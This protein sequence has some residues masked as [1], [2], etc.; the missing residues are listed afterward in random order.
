M[1]KKF[2]F[3]VPWD[4]FPASGSFSADFGMGISIGGLFLKFF[5]YLQGHKDYV[6]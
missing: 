4:L 3:F 6:E 2:W 1:L 5:R